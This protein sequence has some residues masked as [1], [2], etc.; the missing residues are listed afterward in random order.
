MK[1]PTRVS[2]P[3]S[4]V[5]VTS[6]RP[7]AW[8]GVAAVKVVV[9]TNVTDVAAVP[10][11]WVIPLAIY[12]LTFILAFSRRKIICLGLSNRLLNILTFPVLAISA[13]WSSLPVSMILGLHF[14]LLFF[15][16]TAPDVMKPAGA[17]WEKPGWHE[18]DI[19]SDLRELE[20]HH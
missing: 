12:L 16:G 18:V 1:A 2:L 14:M 7:A 20:G 5:T 4:L 13:R 10:L 17:N 11:F 6:T 19:E 15:A 9:L 8:A 3:F